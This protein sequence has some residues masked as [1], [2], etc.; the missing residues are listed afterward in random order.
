[1]WSTVTSTPTLLPQSLTK[2]SNHVSC[3]GTKWLHSSID[4]GPDNFEAGSLNA[5]S[6]GAPADDAA[7]PGDGP[8]DF[9][10]LPHAA[11]NAAA[12]ADWMKARRVI[13]GHGNVPMTQPPSWSEYS[14]RKVGCSCRERGRMPRSGVRLP[15]NVTRQYGE[16]E[17]GPRHRWS[18][19]SCHRSTRRR[20]MGATRP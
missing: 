5:V 13:P 7:S 15:R 4:N 20:A 1:M 18:A 9:L 3:A 14:A 12:A 16:S 19:V 10:S 2:G 8:A 11:R 6:V 17:V